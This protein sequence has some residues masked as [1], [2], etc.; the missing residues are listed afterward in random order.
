MAPQCHIRHDTCS[1]TFNV[2]HPSSL[3]E[4]TM[5]RLRSTNPSFGQS[6]LPVMLLLRVRLH[7]CASAASS[8][9]PS[10]QTPHFAVELAMHALSLWNPVLLGY[11][12]PPQG[13]P[14]AP[15]QLFH[16]K[17]LPLRHFSSYRGMKLATMTLL[18]P[19]TAHGTT[20]PQML[21]GRTW[22]PAPGWIH[23]ATGNKHPRR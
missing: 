7:T 10:W 11:P 20:N 14:A 13:F 18:H 8:L 5:H 9:Q 17:S 1:S 22:H 21:H 16:I 2:I 4:S 3:V 23:C 6:I 15:S 12:P 19:V